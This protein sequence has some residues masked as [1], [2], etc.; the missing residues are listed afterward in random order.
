M[1]MITLEK[2]YGYTAK[3]LVIAT[4]FDRETLVG[5]RYIDVGTG[6]IF[7]VS[8]KNLYE[9]LTRYKFSNIELISN[10]LSWSGSVKRYPTI[11]KSGEIKNENTATVI[12]IYETD[13]TSR[14]R[15]VNM[16]GKQV[17]VTMDQAILHG[18]KFGLTNAKVVTDT[19]NK[20]PY[21]AG[22]NGSLTYIK[23]V[24][25][26]KY[27]LDIDG[28]LE[29]T[30][31][32]YM[33]MDSFEI[34]NFSSG[35]NLANVH[36]FTFKPVEVCSKIK[37]LY[38]NGPIMSLGST[39]SV[40][41]AIEGLPNLETL[42]INSIVS[43]SYCSFKG[44][45]SLKHIESISIDSINGDAFAFTSLQDIKCKLYHFNTVSLSA[46]YGTNVSMQEILD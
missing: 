42:K 30:F 44:L 15:L 26:I 35:V 5:V 24:E 43:F 31:P 21:I 29:I 18:K 46:F 32:R 9:M 37:S 1:E 11:Y 7:N 10:K 25:R 28:D 20:V 41:M 33:N 40:G 2:T 39:K 6:E 17:V 34:S 16:N 4:F 45:K 23:D 3:Y 12:N 38:I 19:N 36:S 27:D 22:I 14:V 13:K 8:I